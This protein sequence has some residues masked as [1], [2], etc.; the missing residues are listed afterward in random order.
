[1]IQPVTET[2]LRELVADAHQAGIITLVVGAVIDSGDR[3]LL[4]EDP[5]LDF[6]D[7]HFW[8]IPSFGV[9]P[10]ETLLDA[11]DRGL[12][13]CGVSLEVDEVTGYLGCFDDDPQGTELIR[14]FAFTATIE[15]SSSICRSSRSAHQW[16]GH[17]DTP[18]VTDQVRDLL[19]AYFSSPL[20]GTGRSAGSASPAQSSRRS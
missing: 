13:T 4:F 18:A 15:D 1:M 5:H 17:C 14:F 9:Y 11:L 20:L 10:G 6:D 12:T 19:A 16:V 7:P 2:L 8:Q 3:V